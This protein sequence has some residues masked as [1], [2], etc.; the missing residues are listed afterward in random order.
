MQTGR[1]VVTLKGHADTIEVGRFSADGK[2]V[3]TGGR[4]GSAKMWDAGTGALLHSLDDHVGT[5]SSVAFSPRGDILATAGGDQAAKLWEVA[6]GKVIR[7]LP[8]SAGAILAMAFDPAGDVLAIAAKEPV[9]RVWDLTPEVRSPEEVAELIARRSVLRMVDGRLVAA[10]A[11]TTAGLSGVTGREN[12][13]RPTTSPEDAAQQFIAALAGGKVDEVRPLI[14]DTADSRITDLREAG[15][16][17]LHS[18]SEL[19]EG[20]KAAGPSCGSTARRR[21]SPSI[22]RGGA[23]TCSS[24]RLAT[25]GKS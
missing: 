20:A 25:G 24:S 19:F 5:V 7:S 17:E 12:A 14:A 6:S 3:V 21:T 16:Q 8:A 22:R 9:A 4:D 10:G 18:L 1:P 13:G 15:S 11:T 2:L 23:W